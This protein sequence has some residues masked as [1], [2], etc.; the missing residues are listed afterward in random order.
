MDNISGNQRLTASTFSD[1][2]RL[3]AGQRYFLKKK[4]KDAV[5]TKEEWL[6]VCKKESITINLN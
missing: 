1:I 2:I 5:K 6:D 4:Y 3:N